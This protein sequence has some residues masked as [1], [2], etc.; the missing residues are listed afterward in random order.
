MMVGADALQR[1][2][3]YAVFAADSPVEQQQGSSMLGLLAFAVACGCV[4]IMFWDWKEERRRKTTYA[5]MAMTSG[6]TRSRQ[7]RRYQQSSLFQAALA[8]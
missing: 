7:S 5:C 4:V 1:S 2:I 6:N 8:A 3:P